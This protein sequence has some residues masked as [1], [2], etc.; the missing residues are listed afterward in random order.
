MRYRIFGE[1]TGLR[2][3]E[4]ALGTG[5][6]G[7]NWGGADPADARA[8]FDA[9]RDA[10]GNF[11]DCANFYQLG[12]A[13]E[14]LGELI[15][16]DRDQLVIGTKYSLGN[17]DFGGLQGTGNSR[18]TMVRAVEDSLKRLGTDRI[19]IYWAH[20][21][22]GVTPIDEIL[23]AFD[24]LVTAGKILHCGLSNFPAWRV[25]RGALL[26]DMR[27]WSPLAA[28]QIEYNLVDRSAERELLPMAAAL[29]LAA[30]VYSPLAAGLLTGKFRASGGAPTKSVR[31]TVRLEK[32]PRDTAILDALFDLAGETGTTPTHI[33]IAWLRARADRAAGAQIPILGPRTPEQLTPA[34]EALTLDLGDDQVERLDSASRQGKGVPHDMIDHSASKAK[35]FADSYDR[36]APGRRPIP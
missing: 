6:F 27:G 8:I 1:R 16:A 31:A 28:I 17:A 13:E 33:A 32:T 29:G 30:C 35:L 21:S 23:R 20:M 19:D 18:K 3:S 10:G 24:D 5:N 14:T 22:D 2:V 36:L 7:T 25:S 4:L 26:A 11:L 12:Q 34:L 9:Y 15:Q